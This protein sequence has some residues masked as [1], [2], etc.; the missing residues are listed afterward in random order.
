[1]DTRARRIQSAA[2]WR[3]DTGQRE[4]PGRRGQCATP[5]PVHRVFDA[6]L[7]PIARTGAPGVEARLLLRAGSKEERR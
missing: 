5:P 2:E 4:S 7:E 6:F 3:P 1:M